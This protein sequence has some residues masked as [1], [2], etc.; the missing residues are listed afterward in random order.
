VRLFAA[1]FEKGSMGL[2]FK[3]PIESGSERPHIS[4]G[5]L[6]AQKVFVIKC[7]AASIPFSCRGIGR[8]FPF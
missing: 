3:R 1:A 8:E 2:F 5:A 6:L 4:E 7:A